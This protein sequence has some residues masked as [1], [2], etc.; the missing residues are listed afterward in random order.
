MKPRKPATSDLTLSGLQKPLKRCEIVRNEVRLLQLDCCH[1]PLRPEQS[2][3]GQLPFGRLA[4]TLLIRPLL[5][6][7]RNTPACG[8]LRP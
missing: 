8:T 5:R 4:T 7:R 1:K 3:R 6:T 2:L